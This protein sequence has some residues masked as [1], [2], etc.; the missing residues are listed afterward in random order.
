MAGKGSS[1]VEIVS[2]CNSGWK[3]P[4]KAANEWMQEHMFNYY[5]KGDLKDSTNL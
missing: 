4:P 3:M 2:T 5:P 1:L